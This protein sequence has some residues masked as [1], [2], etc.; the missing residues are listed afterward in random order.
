VG[1]VTDRD[2][3]GRAIADGGNLTTMTA[4]D[5]M[6]K[7]VLCCSPDDDIKVAIETMEVK[8]IRSSH[9]A[10]LIITIERAIELRRWRALTARCALDPDQCREQTPVNTLAKCSE[11]SNALAERRT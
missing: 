9:Q 3:T 7:D 8:Q 11:R 2:I 1:I 10:T 5:V 6:T 4:K